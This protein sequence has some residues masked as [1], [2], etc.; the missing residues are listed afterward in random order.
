M[1]IL[2][3]G[4][5][6]HAK[7]EKGQSGFINIKTGKC[8]GAT[9]VFDALREHLDKYRKEIKFINVTD[10]G[11]LGVYQHEFSEKT[12]TFLK[13]NCN[14]KD[15]TSNKDFI[16]SAGQLT[17]LESLADITEDTEILKEIENF[18]KQ[19]T[20]KEKGEFTACYV[21]FMAH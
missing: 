13:N 11:M 2:K 18:T 1:K 9:A 20:K 6:F 16:V 14:F 4:Q 17:D 7:N 12:V 3:K 21:M 8:V 15:N 5:N 19:L 10:V